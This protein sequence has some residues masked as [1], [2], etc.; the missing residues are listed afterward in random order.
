MVCCAVSWTK[1]REW[2]RRRWCFGLIFKAVFLF[3][4]TL[5]ETAVGRASSLWR[6]GFKDSTLSVS[7]VAC[8]LVANVE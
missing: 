8:C 5:E 6:N 3:L 7:V 2:K 1:R 4:L